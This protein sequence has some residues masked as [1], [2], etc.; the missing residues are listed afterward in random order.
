MNILFVWKHCS[1]CEKMKMIPGFQQALQAKGI[2][3]YDLGQLSEDDAYM[4][5]FKLHS[6]NRTIPLLLSYEKDNIGK[7]RYRGKIE[8]SQ[9]ISRAIVGNARVSPNRK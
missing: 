3:M 8:G 2:K 5:Q 7:Y 9:N 6:P 4:E 1:E